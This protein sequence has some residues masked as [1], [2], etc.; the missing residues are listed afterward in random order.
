MISICINEFLT[1]KRMHSADPSQN[2][3]TSLHLL[4]DLNRR[5]RKGVFSGLIQEKTKNHRKILVDDSPK[6]N[7]LKV[8]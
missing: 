5:P 3:E 8:N 2:Y 1:Q 6:P 7:K 4:C